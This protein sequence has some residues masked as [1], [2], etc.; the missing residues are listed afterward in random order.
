MSNMKK[1]RNNKPYSSTAWVLKGITRSIPGWLKFSGMRL[2]LGCDGEILFNISINDIQKVEFPW[3]YFGGGMK[4][5]VEGE[6]YRL[7]FVRPNG[8]SDAYNR[9]F[10]EAG[11]ALAIEKAI[12]ISDG[13]RITRRWKNIM[14]NINS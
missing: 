7:S 3:Y 6:R 1:K 11:P 12:D 13:R 10:P 4:I 8:A 2:E 5:W 9:T 14:N